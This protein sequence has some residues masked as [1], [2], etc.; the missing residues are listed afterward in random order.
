[1]TRA[2]KLT[3][4][5]IDTTLQ[6]ERERTRPLITVEIYLERTL[7]HLRIKNTGLT[8]AKNISFSTTPELKICLGGQNIV[9]SE[10][11]ENDIYF[12][13]NG[14]RS[15]SPGAEIQTI[16]GS[17]QRVKSHYKTLRFG[18]QVNYNDVTGKKYQ[19]DFD[20]DI[21]CYGKLLNVSHKG[22]HEIGTELH[23]IKR[24]L[25]RISS[26]N[27]YPLIRTQDEKEYQRKQKKRLH[28]SQETKK[29]K[30]A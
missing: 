23:E 2:N 13:K 25:I 17:F 8:I 30:K 6:L 19:E 9:P 5:S 21:S 4:K 1:M 26:G 10:E 29:Q 7:I 24:E 22:L 12:L 15:L 16:I 14:L 3:S 18:G 28:Q 27:W 20:I 11:V